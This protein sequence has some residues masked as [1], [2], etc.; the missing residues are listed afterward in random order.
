MIKKNQ[1]NNVTIAPNVLYSK[2][3]K[4]YPYV[5]KYNSDHEKQVNL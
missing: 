1:K 4:V 2:K 5:S 3:E